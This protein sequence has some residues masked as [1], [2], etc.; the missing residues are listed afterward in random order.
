MEKRNDV[1][2]DDAPQ[3]SGL[4]EYFVLEEDENEEVKDDARK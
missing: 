4:G 1:V 3:D 2:V